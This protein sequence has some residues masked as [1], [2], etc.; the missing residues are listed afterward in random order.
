MINNNNKKN[1]D[2]NKIPR[3][4]LVTGDYKY[5]D[6]GITDTIAT[7]SGAVV[8]SSLNVIPTG[9]T[10]QSRVGKRVRIFRIDYMV[11]VT[12]GVESNNTDTA[13]NSRVVLFKDNATRGSSPTYTDIYES[14]NFNSFLNAQNSRRFEIIKECRFTLNNYA[15]WNTTTGQVNVL[16]STKI[17]K[18]SIRCDIPI[19]FSSTGTTGSVA[20]T[21]ENCLLLTFIGDNVKSV[22]VSVGTAFRVYFVDY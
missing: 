5:L 10:A 18:G 6:T 2:V 8:L 3:N 16:P 19:L 12:R 9:T 4:I 22:L 11:Q 7:T 21:I 17:K 13:S 15:Y 1:K 14:G 20:Q